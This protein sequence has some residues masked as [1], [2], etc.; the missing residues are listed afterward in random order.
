M[1]FY[2]FGHFDMY[3]REIID[4]FPGFTPSHPPQEKKQ[5]KFNLGFFSDTF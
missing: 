4:M 5:K 3:S 1:E 2:I